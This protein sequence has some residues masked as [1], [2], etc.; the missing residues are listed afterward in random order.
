ME[1]SKKTVLIDATALRT[2]SGMRGIGR[3]VHGLL[4]GLAETRA[5]WSDRLRL[6]AL[7]DLDTGGKPVLG[8]DLAEIADLAIAQRG[9]TK[10][11]VMRRRRQLYLGRACKAA[12]ADLLHETEALGTP[13]F[14]SVPRLVT[15]YDLIPLRYPAH[16]LPT[17]LHYPLQ[18]GKDWRRYVTA[19]RVI[20][21]SERTRGD[22]IRIL[23]VPPGRIEAV[24]TGID[25]DS[26]ASE[27]G[28]A[29]AERLAPLGL[30]RSSFVVYVGYGDF[31]KNVDGMLATLARVRK[32]S[33][34]DLVW[35]GSLGNK[36]GKLENKVREAGLEGH[37]R[38]L[39]FVSDAVLAALFRTSIA[40]LFLSRLEG[41]GLSVAEAMAVGC[42]V[43]V[44][45]G[46]G[47]DEVAG[48]AGLIVSPDDA[49]AAAAAV[50]AMADPIE[51]ARRGAACRERARIFN[52]RTMAE[53]YVR[54]YERALEGAVR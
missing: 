10:N 23:G 21:I 35:A 36:A 29:D 44:A 48:D 13:L 54:G 52:Q 38:F 26:W 28:S 17:R 42:P 30:A 50:L 37:V 16:Y 3:Y 9:T 53:G 34:I 6:V 45:R 49:D 8:D 39:G 43:V 7:S 24:P 47:A 12:G 20:T 4:H 25:L 11:P 22:A 40:H 46:S 1:R 41:F 32:K 27:S 14:P 19:R 31:R 18:W 2:P 51:R 33:D 15:C 5:A